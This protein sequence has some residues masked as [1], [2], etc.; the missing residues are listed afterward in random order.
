[1][2]HFTFSDFTLLTKLNK[3]ENEKDKEL[4]VMQKGEDIVIF[5]NSLELYL[6][7]RTERI[8][9]KKDAKTKSD[10]QNCKEK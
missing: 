8:N 7:G 2:Q 5:I 1:V 3:L 9:N 6:N 10:C 4:Q